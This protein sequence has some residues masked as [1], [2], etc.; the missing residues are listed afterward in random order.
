MEKDRNTTYY[1]HNYIMDKSTSTI[2]VMGA[3]LLGAAIGGGLGILF[4]PHKGSKTRRR[5]LAKGTDVTDAIKDKFDSL[6][7]DMTEEVD[8]LKS[9]LHQR[10][11]G[12]LVKTDLSKKS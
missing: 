12:E 11:D 10:M 4:A 3:L 1:Q 8:R 6:M 9:N 5:I 2:K 7:G